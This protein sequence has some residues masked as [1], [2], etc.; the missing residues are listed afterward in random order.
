MN[1][2]QWKRLRPVDREMIRWAYNALMAP[3]NC[4]RQPDPID[5]QAF[6]TAFSRE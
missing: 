2:G 1:V 3:S 6:E 5:W 4:G